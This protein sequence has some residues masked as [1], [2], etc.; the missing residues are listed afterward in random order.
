MRKITLLGYFML[1]SI[2]TMACAGEENYV[3]PTA[4]SMKTNEMKNFEKALRSL[5]N[6]ENRPTK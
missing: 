3:K 6:P 1:I 4:E 2:L 5:G